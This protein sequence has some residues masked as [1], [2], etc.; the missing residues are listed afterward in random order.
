MD[1]KPSAQEI[2]KW[3]AEAKQVACECAGTKDFG[4][5]SKIQLA[6]VIRNLVLDFHDKK[7]KIEKLEE[8]I[9]QLKK[10]KES[11]Q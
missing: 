11:G 10:G 2:K 9:A 4:M 5:T 6:F 1:K 7:A 3:T 8:E